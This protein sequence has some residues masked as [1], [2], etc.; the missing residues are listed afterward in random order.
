MLDL[1]VSVYLL[2]KKKFLSAVLIEIILIFKLFCRSLST[3]HR[4]KTRNTSKNVTVSGGG[5]RPTY[6]AVPAHLTLSGEMQRFFRGKNFLSSI[7][8]LY[9]VSRVLGLAPFSFTSTF[10]AKEIGPFGLLYSVVILI[11]VLLCSIISIVQR[12]KHSELL[13]AVVV[14]EF[15]TMFLGGLKAFSSILISITRNCVKSRNIVSKVI[16]IDRGLLN[17]STTTYTKTIIFTLIHVILVYT[18]TT[19]LLTYDT[20]VLTT[21]VDKI[22]VW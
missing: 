3:S 10:E 9:Y 20:L 14:N 7:R 19:V 13:V 17:D 21:A 11:T 2:S 4:K 15:L 5:T 8:P 16:K 1:V 6:P 18:Y 12:V 22:S